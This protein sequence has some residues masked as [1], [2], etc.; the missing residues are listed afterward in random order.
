MTWFRR[1][2]RRRDSVPP[3]RRTGP[4]PSANGASSF[5][6]W[7]E[8]AQPLSSVSAT[9]RASVPPGMNRLAF[10]ALQASFWSADGPRGGAHA[11]LQWHPSYPNS[12]AVNWGGYDRDGAVLSG[13]ESELPSALGNPNTRDYPWE[14]ES[15]YRLTIGPRIIR[16]E[17]VLWPARIRD[18]ATG[19]ET[20]VRELFCPGDHLRDPVVWAELFCDCDQ[21]GVAA[22][23]SDP[24]AEGRDGDPVPVTGGRA[25]YQSY[26]NGGCSNTDVS[27]RDG[28]A[29]LRSNHPRRTPHGARLPWNGDD[30]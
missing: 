21:P 7:W 4:P 5:H 23:W 11:G 20:V 14:T 10:F 15:A 29:M 28:T 1:F 13:T 22:R 16:N 26:Q 24:R 18:L 12:G 2:R 25:T 27:V 30:G 3:E 17:R 6:F 9:L 8:T 19:R